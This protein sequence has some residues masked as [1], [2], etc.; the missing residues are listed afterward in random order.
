MHDDVFINH[1]DTTHMIAKM[2]K[3]KKKKAEETRLQLL[4]TPHRRE[5]LENLG[6]MLSTL[7]EAKKYSAMS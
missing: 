3:K 5:E 6:F 1:D 7:Q 2:E 4:Q